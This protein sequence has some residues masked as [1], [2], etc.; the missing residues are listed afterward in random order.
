MMD[1]LIYKYY[2]TWGKKHILR[3]VVPKMYVYRAIL[4]YVMVN[5]QTNISRP[6]SVTGGAKCLFA[7]Y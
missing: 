7:N 4:I 6:D 1:C 2:Y 3:Q 5:F